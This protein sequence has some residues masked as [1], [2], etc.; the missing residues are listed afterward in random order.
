MLAIDRDFRSRDFNR[1]HDMKIL[2]R[3][4]LQRNSLQ[5]EMES[6]EKLHLPSTE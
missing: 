4:F 1:R 2:H 5:Y 3:M 6:F